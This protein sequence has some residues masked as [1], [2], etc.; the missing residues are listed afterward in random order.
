MLKSLIPA[1]TVAVLGNSIAMA[2]YF[3]TQVPASSGYSQPQRPFRLARATDNEP[4]AALADNLDGLDALEALD[5]PESLLEAPNVGLPSAS[6]LPKTAPSTTVPPLNSLQSLEPPASIVLPE[7]LELPTPKQ[8]DVPAGST[9]LNAVQSEVSAQDIEMLQPATKPATPIPGPIDF[10]QAIEHQQR[11]L[12][13]SNQH[14][15]P[16]VYYGAP[17]HAGFS[18]QTFPSNGS[19]FH[20]Q[21]NSGCSDCLTPLPYRTPQLPPS[22]SFHGHFKANP[23]H[24]DIWANYPAEA[25]AAC[26]H[27]RGRLAPPQNTGCQTCEL[28]APSPCR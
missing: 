9:G 21:S 1:L 16:S 13:Y 5:A 12:A 14:S 15:N 6:D 19:R 7:R 8:T 27:H 3:G 24:S 4:P 26:A 17:H 2:Q 25:A 20:G 28:V 22:N 10:N 11:D 18:G 23:C